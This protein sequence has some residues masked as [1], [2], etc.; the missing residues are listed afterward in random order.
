MENNIVEH[1]NI[2]PEKCNSYKLITSIYRSIEGCVEAQKD[3][4]KGFYRETEGYILSASCQCY[5][6]TKIIQKVLIV[7]RE[8]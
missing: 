5:A 8:N 4:A 2:M 1:F 6:I 3:L 7:A